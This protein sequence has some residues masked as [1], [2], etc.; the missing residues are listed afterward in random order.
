MDSIAGESIS[1]TVRALSGA[2]VLTSIPFPATA[3]VREVLERVAPVLEKD[4]LDLILLH[5]YT[6]LSADTVLGDLKI[7]SG[8]I[9]LS[10]VVS[11]FTT[12]AMQ[13]LDSIADTMFLPTCE[14]RENNKAEMLAAL[15]SKLQAEPTLE[16][17]VAGAEVERDRVLQECPL[18]PREVAEWVGV[19]AMRDVDL[20]V[21][22]HGFKLM[23]AS[24]RWTVIDLQMSAIREERKLLYL[25]ILVLDYT[26][27][28][29]FVDCE[30]EMARLLGL[31]HPE[32]YAGSVWYAE[33]YLEL[34]SSPEPFTLSFWVS[35]MNS[36]RVEDEHGFRSFPTCICKSMTEFFRLWLWR[37]N[38][39]FLPDF[40]ARVDQTRWKRSW[41][42][43]FRPQS[44]SVALAREE[45]FRAITVSWHA[46]YSMYVVNAVDVN[47]LGGVDVRVG[48]V[49]VAVN[50]DMR[51]VFWMWPR[52]Y[53]EEP[54]KMLLTIY[55]S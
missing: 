22:P 47:A 20:S 7:L 24:G 40:P 54:P 32:A 30:G 28:L 15:R 46:E 3:S 11:P 16:A 45:E 50:G 21:A 39:P 18:W 27:S 9:D 43:V 19:L 51:R 8:A 49:I 35:I 2:S 13:L 55:R 36:N 17:R 41:Q 4:R 52:R 14:K 6:D 1:V 12:T 42:A 44:V 38:V 48:D 5:E 53:N 29:H 31:P 25:N 26:V 23:G 34:C 37:E 33:M 10:C